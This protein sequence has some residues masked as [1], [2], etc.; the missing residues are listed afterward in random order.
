M[1]GGLGFVRFA[2]DSF[3]QNR[4]LLKSRKKMKD[5]P[6]VSGKKTN[7]KPNPNYDQISEWTEYN[8]SN[9]IN[10]R[11]L[12]YITLIGLVGLLTAYLMFFE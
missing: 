7:R 6:T 3:K 9:Q 8:K 11:R 12:I 10:L 2:K 5:N 4:A 1:A